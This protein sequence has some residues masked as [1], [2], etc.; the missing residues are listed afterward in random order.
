MLQTE[1][2]LQGTITDVKY[3]GSMNY[4]VTV[5]Y[6]GFEGNELFDPYDPYSLD[7]QVYYYPNNKRLFIVLYDDVVEF[8]PEG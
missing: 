7:Y 3:Y 5:Y 8:S 6:E 4:I 2:W 1:F